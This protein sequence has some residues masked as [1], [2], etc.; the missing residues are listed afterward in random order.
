MKSSS[1]AERFVVAFFFLWGGAETE[2]EAALRFEAAEL[3]LLFC[4]AGIVALLSGSGVGMME[5][6][7][8]CLDEEKQ[9]H[10][11]CGA[12]KGPNTFFARFFAKNSVRMD[13]GS[14]VNSFSAPDGIS[15]FRMNLLGRKKFRQIALP[16]K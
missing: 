15:L 16:N 9:E 11:E 4:A 7:E 8:Q 10:E 2:V 6:S 13:P 12:G 1:L 3:C 5:A 14:I